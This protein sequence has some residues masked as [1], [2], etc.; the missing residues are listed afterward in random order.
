[1]ILLPHNFLEYSKN[2]EEIYG[3][4]LAMSQV[5]YRKILNHLNLKQETTGKTLTIGNSKDVERVV[6]LKY[7]NIFW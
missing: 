3:N 1:M 4:S 5:I 6:P 2:H 7:L